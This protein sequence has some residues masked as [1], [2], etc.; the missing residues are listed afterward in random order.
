M[1]LWS[2]QDLGRH[3]HLFGIHKSLAQSKEQL[4]GIARGSLLDLSQSFQIPHRVTKLSHLYPHSGVY[5]Q[6]FISYE[7][8]FCLEGIL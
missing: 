6:P 4:L 5:C 2:S 8:A 3:L 7:V 1:T